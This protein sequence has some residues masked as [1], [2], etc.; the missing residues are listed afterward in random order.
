M[1]WNAGSALVPRVPLSIVSCTGEMCGRDQRRAGGA[2][3]IF[4][5]QAPTMSLRGTNHAPEGDDLVAVR[6]RSRSGWDGR[7][8]SERSCEVVP[9]AR[10]WVGRTRAA[11]SGCGGSE[12]SARKGPRADSEASRSGLVCSRKARPHG[13]LHRWC[14]RGRRARRGSAGVYAANGARTRTPVPVKSCTLRVT[15]V[16]P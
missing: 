1:F 7:V 12:R 6:N 10:V 4:G 5:A 3:I 14:P 9:G 15:T 2:C 13:S 11:R 16:R 8:D